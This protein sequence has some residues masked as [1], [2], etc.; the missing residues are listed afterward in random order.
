MLAFC[1]KNE[2]TTTSLLVAGVM[3]AVVTVIDYV[4]PVW[5][6]KKAGGSRAGVWGATIG[7]IIGLF[8]GILGVI[9]GPFLGALI[10]ELLSD[11]PREK[12]FKVACI[13]FVA[14][15]L[16]TGMKMTYSIILMV[17]IFV[18][19]WNLLLN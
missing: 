11:T 10:G 19:V 2:I 17:M 9:V 6:T 1:D 5:F 8:M 18:E 16:T 14:F 4:A 12:A 3:A 7:L 13:N 15:I